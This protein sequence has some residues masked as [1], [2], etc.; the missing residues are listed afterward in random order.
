MSEAQAI[1]GRATDWASDDSR[2]RIR[3]RYAADRRLQ[4]FGILA[5]TLAI[6]LLGILLGSIIA[7]GYPA[8]VQTKVDLPISVDASKVDAKDPSKANFK[9]L[10]REAVAKFGPAG[11]G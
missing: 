11:A 10:I 8:F 2:R 1:G 9:A 6:G 5:I 7:N 3:R 4:A